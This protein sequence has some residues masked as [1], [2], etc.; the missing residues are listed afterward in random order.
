[1]PSNPLNLNLRFEIHAFPNLI[2][3]FSDLA[4]VKNTTSIL[5]PALNST[6]YDAGGLGS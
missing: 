4:L 3:S 1:M 2:A 5:L 6:P